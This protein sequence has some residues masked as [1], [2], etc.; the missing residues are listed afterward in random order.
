[1]EG[2]KF[3][4]RHFIFQWTAPPPLASSLFIIIITVLFSAIVS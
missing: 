4:K 3:Y 2:R 1:M